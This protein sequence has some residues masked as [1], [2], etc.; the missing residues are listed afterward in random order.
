MAK[1]AAQQSVAPFLAVVQYTFMPEDIPNVVGFVED[2]MSVM[3][4]LDILGTT[5]YEVS[6]RYDKQR[7][8]WS[9]CLKGADRECVNAGKWMYGNGN[10]LQ[11]AYCSAFY[12]HF[13]VFKQGEWKGSEAKGS[14]I[15]S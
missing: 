9:V 2:G 11:L 6:V 1:N 12:K 7:E 13:V 10:T 14:T 4:A 3:D 15:L 5:G 8:S